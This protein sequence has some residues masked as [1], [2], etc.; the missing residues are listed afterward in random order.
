MRARLVV[1]VGLVMSC[2]RGPLVVDDSADS[3]SGETTGDEVT[4]QPT[5]GG[6][7]STGSDLTSTGS[8]E[9]LGGTSTSGDTSSSSDGST[10]TGTEESS[11]SD[12]GNPVCGDGL[13]E[14]SEACDDGN[15]QSGDGCGADCTLEAV[16]GNGVLEIGELCDDGNNNDGDGCSADCQAV[17]VCGDGVV[18]FPEICD[19]GNNNDGDGCEADCTLTPPV[20]GDGVVEGDEVCDDGNDVDGGPN[21][22]CKNDCTVFVPPLCEAPVEYVV[23]DEGLDLTDKADKNAALRAFGICNDEPDNS[24]LTSGFAF[25]VVNEASWQVARGFGTA[26]IDHDMDP[27]TPHV[28]VFG[29]REGEALLMLSTGTIAA[30]NGEGLVVAADGSQVS[31]NNNQNPDTPNSLPAP[32]SLESGSN[33]G[34]GGTPMMGCDGVGDCSETLFEQWNKTNDPNDQLFFSFDAVP[35]VGTFAYRFDVAFC[36]SEWPMGVGSDFNDMFVV[37]QSD[38]TAPDPDAMPPVDPFT[39]NMLVVED[40]NEPG[41][42]LPFTATS[43]DQEFIDEGFVLADPELAGTGFDGH[44]C[45]AWRRVQGRVQP[46]ATIHFGF[47]LADMGS[48][49]RATVVLLDRFRW[50][51]ALCEDP[52]E[53]EMP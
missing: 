1:W 11:S 18:Q 51:C 28:P 49:Q 21:D 30:P 34:L 26:T 52:D 7:A 46:G 23:C 47:F 22:F 24:V 10:S 32:L 41:A 5:S 15:Q 14:G 45:S 44:A 8:E 43:L 27:N 4:S 35:P 31:N 25:A 37:W 2:G 53:C 3:S 17:E 19:D 6:E 36:S 48:S 33:G 38:P 12:T 16:C 50:H 13:V 9:S 39:G 29:A 42:F 40:P 20:C